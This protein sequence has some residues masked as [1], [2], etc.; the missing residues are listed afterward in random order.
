MQP[1][2]SVVIP[3]YNY[4]HFLGRALASVFAQT[5]APIEC[6]VVDDGSTDDTPAVLA[7]Y[8]DRV[9]VIKRQR[10][11]PA[12]ARNAGVEAAKGE[13]VAFLDADDWW[14]KDKIA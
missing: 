14:A 12:A 11:G 3:T 6:I 5:Y 9:R 1:L 13:F 2:V 4:G 10:G 7:Q 8:G